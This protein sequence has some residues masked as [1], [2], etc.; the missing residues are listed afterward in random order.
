MRTY[1]IRVA[2]GALAVFVIG[3]M[4]VTGIRA[5]KNK[6]TA[7]LAEM[8]TGLGGNASRAM[9]AGLRDSLAFKLD[10]VRL[11]SLRR[12]KIDKELANTVPDVTA[13]VAL[14]SGV[15]PARVRSC[16]IVPLSQD[17]MDQFRCADSAEGGL[18]TVGKVTFEGAGFD[19][20]LR[21]QPEMVEKLTKGDAFHLNADLTGPME[22]TVRKGD[23]D[24]VRIKADSN[25]ARIRVTGKDGREIVNMRADSTG[26][27]LVVDSAAR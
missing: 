26:F 11:G 25:G 2:L 10:G 8:K 21:L 5:T 6:A 9:L 1:W 4:F 22:A 20:P 7:A 12:I 13:I 23:R 15:D 16:D 3:M 27:S 19:R 24:V 17:E 14:D 18:Q